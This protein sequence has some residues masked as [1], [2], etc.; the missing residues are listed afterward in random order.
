MLYA[1]CTPVS[2]NELKPGDL[3]FRYKTVN[4]KRDYHHVGVYVGRGLAIE[5]KG[6]D[7]GVVIRPLYASGKSYWE[8]AGRLKIFM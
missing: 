8:C 4:G 6:R 7:D 5:A 1:R 3:L 2:M